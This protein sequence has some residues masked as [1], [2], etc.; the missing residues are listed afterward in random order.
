MAIGCQRP[1]AT[2]SPS[3]LSVV[4]SKSLTRHHKSLGL[5]HAEHLPTAL[6]HYPNV[7]ALNLSLCL[8]VTNAFLTIVDVAHGNVLRSLGLSKS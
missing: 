4:P 3:P 7:A 5:L 1:A 2:T 8:R 6:A